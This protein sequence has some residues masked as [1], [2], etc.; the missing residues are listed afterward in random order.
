MNLTEYKQLKAH[1]ALMICP[2]APVS[3]EITISPLSN[4]GEPHPYK[5]SN[6]NKKI[7]FIVNTLSHPR[8]ILAQS[9]ATAAP[10]F[11]QALAVSL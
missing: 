2:L 3:F 9:Q 11:A 8:K 1:D 6:T 10:G 5:P 4:F 7:T